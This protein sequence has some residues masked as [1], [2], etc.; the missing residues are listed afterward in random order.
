MFTANNNNTTVFIIKTAQVEAK[1][2]W[3]SMWKHAKQ[4]SNI[5]SNNLMDSRRIGELVSDS[6]L[7]G[8]IKKFALRKPKNYM[9]FVLIKMKGEI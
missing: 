5:F 3:E 1:V 6:S 2:R 9:Y 8:K 7:I 4:Q